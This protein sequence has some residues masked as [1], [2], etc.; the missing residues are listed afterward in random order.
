[1]VVARREIKTSSQFKTVV[2]NNAARALCMTPII[3]FNA[4]IHEYFPKI[5]AG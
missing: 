1:M 4:K 5:P 2:P 3:G